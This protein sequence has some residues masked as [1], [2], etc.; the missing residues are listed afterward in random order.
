MGKRIISQR[1][2]SGSS[3]YRAP[4]HKYRGFTKHPTRTDQTFQGTVLDLIRCPAHSAP[5]ALVEYTITEDAIQRVLMPA[6]EGTKVGESIA[7]G[8]DA[9]IVPGSTLPLSSIPEGVAIFNIEGTPGDGGKYVRSSGTS[10]KI[11]TKTQNKIIVTLPS[12]KQKQFHPECRASLGIIAGGGRTDKPLMKAGITYYKMKAKNKLWPKTSGS[13]MNAVDHPF[14]NKRSS[15][16][17]KAKPA[18]KNAPPG[19]KVGL[20]RPRRTGKK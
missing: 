16:K 2:G 20:I 17:S 4:G 3:R 8:K 7:C 6:S 15:R 19:R 14:G 12:K 5:L 11:V 18:P 1:R 10:A 13:A 9:E